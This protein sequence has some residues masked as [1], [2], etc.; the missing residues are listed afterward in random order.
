MQAED[1]KGTPR[2]YLRL[3]Y[4]IR[5]TY[6]P[7]ADRT[8]CQRNCWYLGICGCLRVCSSTQFL[9]LL[10]LA[11]ISSYSGNQLKRIVVTSSGAAITDSTA[12]GVLDESNW[13][14]SDIK[15][16]N[17]KGKAASQLAKYRASKSLAE[18]GA[19]LPSELP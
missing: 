2:P 11:H 19:L 4:T 12:S 6:P 13:N 3:R 1:P 9:V 14:E 8:C 10:F 5:L 17:E 18:K 7:R 15:E 16:I